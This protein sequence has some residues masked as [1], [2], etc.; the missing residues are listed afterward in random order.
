MVLLQ[1]GRYDRSF[2]AFPSSIEI[3]QFRNRINK[4]SLSSS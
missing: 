2:E 3:R 4:V 1:T